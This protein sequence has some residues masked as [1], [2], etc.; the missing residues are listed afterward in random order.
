MGGI[1]L[2]KQSFRQ[3]HSEFSHC[4]DQTFDKRQLQKGWC[5]GAHSDALRWEGKVEGVTLGHHGRCMMLTALI[6]GDQEIEI[7][8]EVVHMNLKAAPRR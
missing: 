2:S 8:Q 4:C 1:P 7:R 6:L 3:C 5:I